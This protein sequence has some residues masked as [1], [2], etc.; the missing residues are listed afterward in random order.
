MK[1]NYC[2][3]LLLLSFNTFTQD[4]FLPDSI[5]KNIEATPINIRLKVDGKLDESVWN[6][7]QDIT[8]FIQIEPNQKSSCQSKNGF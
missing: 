5:K 8:N 2:L 1:K 4:I 3:I 6:Q 7:A